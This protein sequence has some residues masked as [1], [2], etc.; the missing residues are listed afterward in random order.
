M[1]IAPESPGIFESLICNLHHLPAQIEGRLHS[2]LQLAHVTFLVSVYGNEVRGKHLFDDHI[3]IEIFDRID[4]AKTAGDHHHP[5]DL[6]GEIE[7]RHAVHD[8]LGLAGHA[9]DVDRCAEDD[10]ILFHH[11]LAQHAH[12]VVDMA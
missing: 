8:Y 1:E 4:A 7:E 11:F 2:V 9:V 3:E 12:V 6:V 10:A 5:S